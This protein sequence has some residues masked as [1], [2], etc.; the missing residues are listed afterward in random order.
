MA[1][2]V[3][4]VA[5]RPARRQRYMYWITNAH[6]FGGLQLMERGSKNM[7]VSMDKIEGAEGVPTSTS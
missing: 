4:G 2:G 1:T 6:Q 7:G 3:S 5:L